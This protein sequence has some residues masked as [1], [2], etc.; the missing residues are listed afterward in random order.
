MSK[1]NL[2]LGRISDHRNYVS[3]G[4]ECFSITL[5]SKFDKYMECLKG[6]APSGELLSWHKANEDREDFREGYYPLYFNQVKYSNKAQEDLKRVT[7]LL[8]S[9]KDVALICFCKSSDRCH[10]GIIGDWFKKKGYNVVYK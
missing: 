9:G 2:Y 1:G 4:I 8:D 10:R 7:L 6:L 5:S 3:Q